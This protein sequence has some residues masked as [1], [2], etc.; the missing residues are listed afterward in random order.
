MRMKRFKKM[1]VKTESFVL[2]TKV[3]KMT[4]RVDA[5]L[6]LMSVDVTF[7]L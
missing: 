5:S 2:A 3:K 4:S 6:I 7:K 1:K